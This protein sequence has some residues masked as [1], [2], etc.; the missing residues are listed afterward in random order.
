MIVTVHAL[1]SYNK[2]IGSKLIYKGTKH[3]APMLNVKTSHTAVLVNERWVHESTGHS[4]VR[5]ISYDLWKQI[6]IEVGRVKLENR[7][8][9]EIADEYRKI[10]DKE[11]DYPGVIYLGLCIIP[12]FFGLKLPKKNKWE[13]PNKYFC[14][15]VL[16][17]LTG[18]Y[19]GMSAPIQILESLKNEQI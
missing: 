14:C 18:K 7:E 15:E 3:L 9:Q 19:Y 1:F 16:G 17:K 6:N 12:T 2:L 8:Y 11:Y 10:K 4:G 5:V 13:S